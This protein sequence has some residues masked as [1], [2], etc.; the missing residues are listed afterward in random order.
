ML[1]F[2]GMASASITAI[3]ATLITIVDATIPDAIVT[4]LTAAVDP[5]SLERSIC[6]AAWN[7]LHFERAVAWLQ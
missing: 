3:L 5:T 1:T 6:R 4:T 7:I 2:A